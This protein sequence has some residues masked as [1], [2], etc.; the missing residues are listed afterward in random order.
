MFRLLTSSLQD[1]AIFMLDP[2]GRVITWNDAARRVK[3]YSADEIM[4]Q[5]FSIFYEDVEVRAGKPAWELVVAARDGRFEDEGWRLRR[6]GT[7]FWANVVI[8]ALRDEQNR[9]RGFGKVTRDMTEKKLY[10]ERLADQQSRRAEQL[11]QH[12][13]RMAQLEKIKR[14]F[15]NLASHEL[16]GPLSVL[17]G[18]ISMVED[19]TLTAEQFVQF[20]PL[21]SAKLRQIDLLVMQMLDTARL[22]NAKLALEHE[23]F[24]VGEIA[25]RVV[26]TFRPLA[27]EGHRLD[28][29][30]PD[31]PVQLIGDRE[32]IEMVLSNLVDNAIKYSP[33]GGAVTCLVTATPDRVFVSVQDEGL[34]IA[35]T[36]FGQLFT[37][38]GRIV[39]AENAHIGGT[40]LGLYLSREIVRQLGG[41]IL[42]ESTLARGSRFTVALPQRAEGEIPT[43]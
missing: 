30:L 14:D 21:L 38:F 8:T 12:A 6:D 15:L 7:K 4:G 42:V 2:E 32:K 40:G 9:L 43:A 3:G 20:V 19:G 35:R 18:Y 16:R 31:G 13:Q 28:V 39:T 41:D 22:E 10:E 34:G 11:R 29:V 33:A 24:D 27:G 36:D 23:A 25:S 1:Y 37:P 5:H 26:S 17:R